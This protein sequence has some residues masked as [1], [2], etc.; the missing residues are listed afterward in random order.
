MTRQR[1]VAN[2]FTINASKTRAII[3]FPKMKK[4]VFDYSINV[5]VTNLYST[6]RQKSRSEY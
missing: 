4:S 3:I 5:G 6:K 2:K 1:M